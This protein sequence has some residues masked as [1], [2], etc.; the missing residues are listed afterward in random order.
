MLLIHLTERFKGKSFKKA[1]KDNLFQELFYDFVSRPVLSDKLPAVKSIEE[2]LKEEYYDYVL[3]LSPKE[4]DELVWD[5]LDKLNIVEL[6]LEDF[7][8]LY[9]VLDADHD[10]LISIIDNKIFDD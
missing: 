4:H 5:I 1:W 2:I 6:N 10:K 8:N 9:I 7:C 3:E